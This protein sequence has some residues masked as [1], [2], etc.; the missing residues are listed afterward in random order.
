MST[1]EDMHNSL[2]DMR[3]NFEAFLQ[4]VCGPKWYGDAKNFAL[5][6][7]FIFMA[8]FSICVFSS[9]PLLFFLGFAVI[10]LFIA[11]ICFLCIEGM[12]LLKYISFFE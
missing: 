7:P 2:N 11:L 8:I 6:H 10:T 4:S 12:F 9:V 5:R 3:E 1:A